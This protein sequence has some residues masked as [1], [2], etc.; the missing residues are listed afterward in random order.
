MTSH[1]YFAGI[2]WASRAHALCVVDGAGGVV[3][4]LDIPHSREGIERPIGQLKSF[5]AS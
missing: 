2:D 4:R 1:S 3:L 5:T